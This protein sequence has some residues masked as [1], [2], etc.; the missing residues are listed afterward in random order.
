MDELNKKEFLEKCRFPIEWQV[1]DMLPNEMLEKLYKLYQSNM[2][3]DST[4]AGYRNFRLDAFFYWLERDLTEEQ[5]QNLYRLSFFEKS[6]KYMRSSV[7]RHKDC[8]ET[9]RKKLFGYTRKEIPTLS[10]V[11]LA[12]LLHFPKAWLTWEMYPDE[13]FLEHRQLF[14]LGNESDSENERSETFHYW[15]SRELT[16][17][18]LLKLVKLSQLDPEPLMAENIQAHIKKHKNCTPNIKKLLQQEPHAD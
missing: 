13:M 16:E 1:W 14:Q 8:T 10:K 5:V 12:E 7:N 6:G 17:D 18:Q 9:L 2:E 4:E 3:E 15:L 11:R